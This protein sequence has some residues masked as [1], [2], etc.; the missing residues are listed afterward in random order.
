MG[1]VQPA[2]SDGGQLE[3]GWWR[4]GAAGGWLASPAP[5]QGTGGG[6]VIGGWASQGEGMQEIGGTD[7]VPHQVG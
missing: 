2:F 4:G 5:D 1:G 3:L 6:E 7:R